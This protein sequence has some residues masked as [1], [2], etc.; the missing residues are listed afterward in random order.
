MQG[1]E[2]DR[3]KQ[4]VSGGRLEGASVGGEERP[5]YTEEWPCKCDFIIDGL[6]NR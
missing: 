1:E 4:T 5:T 6:P 3:A 2:G